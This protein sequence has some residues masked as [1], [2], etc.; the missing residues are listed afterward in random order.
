MAVDTELQEL[1]FQ[2]VT[3]EEFNALDKAGQTGLNQ[4]YLTPDLSTRLPIFT[5]LWVDHKVNDMSWLNADTFSWQSGDVYKAAYEHLASEMHIENLYAWE[6]EEGRNRYT[7]SATPSVGDPVYTASG[8]QIYTV[9]SVGTDYIVFNRTTCPRNASGDIAGTNAETDTVDDITITFYR[10]E[11]GH[12]ICMADQEAN[13]QSLFDATGVAWYYILDTE[14]KQFKLPRE[15]KDG[16]YQY[17][18]VGN[19]T[20]SALEQTAGLNAELFNEKADVDLSNLTAVGKEVCA[21]MVMPS[22]KYID[23]TLATSGSTYTAPADGY[24]F[25]DKSATAQGQYLQINFHNIITSQLAVGSGNRV[26]VY[27]IVSKG[28]NFGV[29]YSLGGATN[30]F[31]FIY[32]NGAK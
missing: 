21:N 16:K 4:F 5:S 25:V 1:I 7:R 28:S 9:E 19:Y 18:F 6:E 30:I 22:N 12:K 24:V 2:E 17:F 10:A 3:Q 26:R 32:A 11:D 20:K 27:A 23:M 8:S 31:R 29:S 14:N 15:P 13:I